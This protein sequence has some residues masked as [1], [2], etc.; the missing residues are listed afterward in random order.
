MSANASEELVCHRV[1]WVEDEDILCVDVF[2]AKA[3]PLV[4]E[5]GAIDK[6]GNNTE[7]NNQ[8]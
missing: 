7:N 5:V 8:S 6:A 4:T 1:A 3:S 2:I